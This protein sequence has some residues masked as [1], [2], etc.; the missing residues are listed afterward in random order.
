MYFDEQE[1]D[2]NRVGE[3]EDRVIQLAILASVLEP[4]QQ[5]TRDKCQER[6]PLT[7]SVDGFPGDLCQNELADDA[8]NFAHHNLRSRD[9]LLPNTKPSIELRV[10]REDQQLDDHID[11]DRNEEQI[12]LI[13]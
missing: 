6:P 1:R 9:L 4:N 13:S 8:P 10:H 3:G 11:S 12:Q 7:G 5:Y 2:A